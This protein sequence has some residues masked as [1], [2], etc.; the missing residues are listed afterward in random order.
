MKPLRRKLSRSWSPH[1][2]AW[3][4]VHTQGKE[5]ASSH[6][7]LFLH[8]NCWCFPCTTCLTHRKGKGTNIY[9]VPA[10]CSV[11]L[12]I[13]SSQE[14]TSP[15]FWICK[16]LSASTS[17]RSTWRWTLLPPSWRQSAE[18]PPSTS[19][20]PCMLLYVGFSGRLK[21]GISAWKTEILWTGGS[22]YCTRADLQRMGT[23]RMI[24]AL[25]LTWTVP[26]AWHQGMTC[27]Q[28]PSRLSLTLSG[29]LC[30]SFH[31]VSL[32]RNWKALWIWESHQSTESIF[33]LNPSWFKSKACALK[34]GLSRPWL[35]RP[36]GRQRQCVWLAWLCCSFRLHP[37]HTQVPST[38]K[39][40]CC[41]IHMGVLRSQ[42]FSTF[43]EAKC[44]LWRS[45][46]GSGS[47]HG[48]WCQ[49][50][51]LHVPALLS[52]NWAPVS[53]YSVLWVLVFSS[54]KG[55]S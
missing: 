27:S 46:R 3:H 44:L 9:Q 17:L 14:H 50:V 2:A 15:M 30:L 5:A 22:H 21:W 18:L 40:L 26:W 49:A 25:C 23:R 33:K 55:P 39:T 8:P 31:R 29:C 6:G 16:E 1:Q 24:P 19:T 41:A 43:H 51:G 32:L 34:A 42:E 20:Q 28:Y 52:T 37:L 35:R 47:A 4:L 45:R 38:P 53:I 54:V 7:D 13:H 48:C 12:H 10:A 36:Q 11:L